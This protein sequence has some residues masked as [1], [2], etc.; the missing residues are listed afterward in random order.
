VR[1]TFFLFFI[2]ETAF[3]ASFTNARGV[4]GTG[5]PPLPPRKGGVSMEGGD[6]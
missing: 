2:E 1:E 4:K 3:F 5:E 6:G